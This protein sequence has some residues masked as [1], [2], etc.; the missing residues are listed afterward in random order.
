MKNLIISTLIFR[1]FSSCVALI[2]SFSFF[3]SCQNDHVTN[4]QD[5]GVKTQDSVINSES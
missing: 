4:L 5:V 2:I 1:V 3:V